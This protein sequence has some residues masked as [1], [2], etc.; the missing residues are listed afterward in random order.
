M[1]WLKTGVIGWALRALAALIAL[2]GAAIVLPAVAQSYPTHPI[3][4]IVPFAPGGSSEIV[5]RTFIAEM[6]RG[7]GEQLVIENRP[8][9]AG[10]VAMQEVAHAEPDGY[11]IILGHVGTLAMNPWMF[12]RLPYDAE[13]EFTPISLLAKVTTIFAVN[14]HFPPRDLREFIVAAKRD[15]GRIYYGSAGNGSAGHLAFEYLKMVSGID[16]VH[17][18][19]KGTGP[20]L[21]D[22]LAGQTQATSAGAGPILPHIRSGKV[23]AIAVGSPQRIAVLPDVGTVAEQGFPGFETSQWYGLIA[24]IRVKPAIINRL[25]TEAARAARSPAVLDR[26]ASDGTLSVGDTPAQFAE[27]IKLEKARWGEV[28]T[29]TGARAE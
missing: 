13:R 14:A 25:A 15:P 5:A 17:A 12:A 28:V 27:F 22:L 23:R 26:L 10:N 9:G 4:L 8:G 21:T 11:T 19:Y 2:P 18:P 6:S 3:R 7:L 1:T 20:Q 24:P 16:V 29:R